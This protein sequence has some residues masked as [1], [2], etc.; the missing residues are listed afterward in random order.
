MKIIED[1][2][3]TDVKRRKNAG[4]FEQIR[5]L[6]G[7]LSSG[8]KLLKVESHVLESLSHQ[9]LHLRDVYWLHEAIVDVQHLFRPAHLQMLS[10]ILKASSRF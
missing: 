5:C 3:E 6:R 8:E 4:N 1:R 9:A 10:H 7:S 2:L